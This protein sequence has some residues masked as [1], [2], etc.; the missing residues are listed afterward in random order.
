MSEALSPGRRRALELGRKLGTIREDHAFTGPD[1]K[2]GGKG[3][4]AMAKVEK[5]QL[6]GVSVKPANEK[7]F[8]FK[9]D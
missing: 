7:P 9:R 5:P 4:S 8:P 1:G 6:E 2:P 3:A